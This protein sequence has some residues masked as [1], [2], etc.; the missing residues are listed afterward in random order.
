[1]PYYEVLCS[2]F[3]RA[4]ICGA[5]WR[6]EFPLPHRAMSAAWTRLHGPGAPDGPHA[7][8]TVQIAHRNHQEREGKSAHPIDAEDE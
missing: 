4:C 3:E 6:G 2:I 1:M 5:I 7:P 8:C